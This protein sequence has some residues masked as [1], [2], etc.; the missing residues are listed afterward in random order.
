MDIKTNMVLVYNPEIAKALIYEYGIESLV[1]IERSQR[2]KGRKAYEFVGNDEL[3]DCFNAMVADVKE[4]RERKRGKKEPIDEDKIFK[5]YC[6]KLGLDDEQITQLYGG[7]NREGSE[8]V[9]G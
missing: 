3:V 2:T 5:N 6:R 7:I 1:G 8:W 9:Y 4:Q